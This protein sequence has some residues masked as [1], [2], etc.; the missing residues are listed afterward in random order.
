[1]NPFYDGNAFDTNKIKLWIK[2]A[3]AQAQ[4]DCF[5]ALLDTVK[6]LRACLFGSMRE[7]ALNKIASAIADTAQTEIA[8]EGIK[9]TWM[10]KG[11]LSRITS[12]LAQS[13][14]ENARELFVSAIQA[15]QGIKDDN[16]RA[17]SLSH[18]ASAMAQT[19]HF[20]IALETARDIKYEDHRSFALSR[21]ASTMAQ[22]SFPKQTLETLEMITVN[23]DEHLP[24]IAGA[25]AE[26]NDKESFK[27]L[28]I[29]CVYYLDA[30]YK[31][32]GLLARLY[33]EQ[34]A[35]IAEVI[36]SSEP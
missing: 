16:D 26:S 4:C 24:E 36:K 9:V 8:L 17:Y 13:E 20:E 21:I 30:A 7:Y 23:R 33:P 29:P 34:A 15:A 2:F 14:K 31:M 11:A 12:A 10:R 25:F 32:C 35:G 5:T 27:H 22:T 19:G 18:I 6:F 28:L 3:S 1:M